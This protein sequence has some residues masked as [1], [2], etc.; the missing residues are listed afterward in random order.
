[1]ER[2]RR[3][4]QGGGRIQKKGNKGAQRIGA[5]H[6][7]S[8]SWGVRVMDCTTTHSHSHTPTPHSHS[9]SFTPTDVQQQ[10]TLSR[11]PQVHRVRGGEGGGEG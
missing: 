2:E 4:Y 7:E 9:P 6:G 8:L 1:M 11:A 10:P 5:M 3:R